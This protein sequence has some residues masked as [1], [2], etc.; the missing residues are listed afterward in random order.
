MISLNS[1][2]LVAVSGGPDS[3]VLLH[4]FKKLSLENSNIKLAI[5]HLNH[6]SRGEDSNKDSVFVVELGKKTK[7]DTFV[8]AIDVSLLRKNTNT[9]FQESA[10]LIR[11]DFLRRIFSQWKGDLIAL[12]HNADDQAE[13]VLINLLRG[14]GLLGLTGIRAQR[15]IFIRPLHGCFRSEIDDYIH[16]HDLKYCSDETNF[17]NKYLRNKV[18]LELIPFLELYNPKIKSILTVTSA[19]LTDDEDYLVKQVDEKLIE[20]DFR[21]CENSY[22]SLDIKLL[23]SQHPA[24]QKR[25]VRHAIFISKGNL[26][27]ISVR[28]ILEILRLVKCGVSSK[29]IHLPNGLVALFVDGKLTFCNKSYVEKVVKKKSS[30]VTLSARINVPGFTD[31]GF[32]GLGFNVSFLSVDDFREFSLSPNIAYF[33]YHKTGPNL[34]MRL[35]RPGDNFIPLG[36]KGRKKIKSFFID[37]KIDQDERK[38]IPFLTTEN[39]FIIW[40]YEKRIGENYRVTDKTSVIVKIEGVMQPAL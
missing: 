18:R 5:A 28:H 36:M 6:L 40:I 29:E 37:E 16:A 20:V 2:V 11:Y 17:E 26:R 31:I 23:N 34:K 3:I 19:I 25:L 7:L 30:V 39:D 38:L 14:S 8:E 10:R 22:T 4:L 35:F 1:R 13:T 33:D 21:Y 9:S 24:M 32:R 15:D 27:S 12:G